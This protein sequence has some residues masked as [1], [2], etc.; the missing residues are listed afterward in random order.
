LPEARLG[1]VQPGL[2]VDVRVD[3]FPGKNFAGVVRRIHRQ[4]EFTP[5]NVQTQE[6]RA[7]QVFQTEVVLEDPDHVLRPGMSAD[8]TIEKR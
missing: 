7:L 6:E 8:V 5:R 3:S 2:K 4:G 1:F